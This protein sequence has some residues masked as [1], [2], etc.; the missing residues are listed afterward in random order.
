MTEPLAQ[1]TVYRVRD[2]IAAR[3]V[4]EPDDVIDESKEFT[5][6]TLTGRFGFDAK[7][8]VAKPDE[9]Q[10]SWVDFLKKG[11][12]RLKTPDNVSNS[13]VLVVKVRHER[14]DCYFAFTFGFGRF[15][16]RPGS[17]ERNYG[18]RVALN[19]IYPHRKEKEELDPVRLRSVDSKTVAANTLRTR[20]QA[21]HRTTFETFDIDVQRDLLTGL[22]GQPLDDRRWGT[23]ITGSDALYLNRPT[24]FE[25]IG[26]LCREVESAY[27]KDYPSEFS[28]VDNIHA[29]R[30]SVL[31]ERL[32]EQIRR[33]LQSGEEGNLELAPPELVDWGSIWKFGFSFDPDPEDHFDEAE[34]A[35]YIE[36]LKRKK[37]LDHLTLDQLTSSHRLDAFD[38]GNQLIHH[39]T[40]FKCLSGEI[41]VN[42]KTYLLSEGDFFEVAPDYIAELNHYLS[43]LKE[44]PGALPASKK[45]EE[46][47]DYNERVAGASPDYLL[48]DKK[49][50]RLSSRTAAIEICDILT[51]QGHFIHVKRKLNSSSLSHLF[52]QGLVSA[53]LLLMSQQYREAVLREVQNAE[54]AK[55]AR[56]DGAFSALF[57]HEVQSSRLEV[58]YA[59]IAK[60]GDE[61]R[62]R[63]KGIAEAMP[64]FSKVN[65]RRCATDL[66]R[67]G[68][69]VSYKRIPIP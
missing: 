43:T 28:W 40:V 5:A 6:H 7:L 20:R 21:D 44:Y 31:T 60:W 55:H 27:L 8:F 15:L 25:Q 4:R 57:R 33:M 14:K 16:L 50:V 59:I 61:R 38:Q 34:L 36:A 12:P 53:D 22:T 69:S 26:E 45:K 52:S 64:L 66:K 17:F 35:Q 51:A 3:P 13:A 19:S 46:E 62:G 32:K 67:M 39:W 18:L 24:P 63:D 10:P 65:L 54:R 2:H 49:T 11:F 30:D 23:R 56:A 9:R 41:E 47:G 37:K 68:Y 58:V 1:L 48:L 29:V 42:G